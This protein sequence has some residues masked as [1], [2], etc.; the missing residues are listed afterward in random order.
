MLL[1]TPRS[2]TTCP[3]LLEGLYDVVFEI[4]LKADGNLT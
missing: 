4:M 1:K 2:S 3:R